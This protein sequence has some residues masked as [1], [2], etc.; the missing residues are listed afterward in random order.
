MNYNNTKRQYYLPLILSL[1]LITGIFIGILL[2]THSSKFN[3]INREQISKN[4]HNYSDKLNNI[5]NYVNQAYVDSTSYDGLAEKAIN[6]MLHNLD[7]HSEYISAAEYNEINDPL[8][9][10]FEGIGVQF[11][12]EK[13]TATV[14]NTISGGPS[15]KVGIK[16][17]DRIVKINGK[18]FIGKK[19]KSNDIMKNL[20]GPKGTKVTVS[21]RRRGVPNLTDFTITRDVIPT[22]S[23]DA[24]YIIKDKT[25]YIRLSKFSSTTYN[26]FMDALLKLQ[27]TGLNK[28]IIDLR[29]NGGGYLEA[30]I[31]VANELLGPDKHIVYTKGMHS[32]KKDIYTTGKG[33]FENNPLVILIDEFSASASEIVT[34]AI[35]DNDRGIIIGRRSFGKGLVQEQFRFKD[36]SAI[37]LTVARYYTPTG[38]CIQKPYKNGLEDYYDKFY[39]GILNGDSHNPDSIHINDSLKFK[40]PKGKIVYGGGGIKPDIYVALKMNDYPD[41]YTK[42]MNKGLIYQFAF[43]YV[44]KNRSQLNKFTTFNIFNSAFTITE[45]ILNEFLDYADKKG[46]KKQNSEDRKAK[47]NELLKTQLKANIARTLLNDEAYIRIENTIDKTVTKALEELGKK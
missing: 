13:D 29:G 30:A 41:Y 46:V 1:I 43:D 40:T 14:L 32:P 3:P 10:K 47:S 19:I 27:K 34:G 37:R 28:L 33:H 9:G 18:N 42:V 26:E 8:M 16:A 25:G 22:Y 4:P 15:V 21:I 39:E 11:R 36:G 6:G 45:P 7:P 38:R 5:I 2:S 44:D 31:K 23:V 24:A 35:Q 12:M 17:G 20:K